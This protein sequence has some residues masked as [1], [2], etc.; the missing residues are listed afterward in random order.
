MHSELTTDLSKL[1]SNLTGMKTNTENVVLIST[2]SFNPVHRCHLSN[3]IRTKEYFENDCG[4]NVLAGY[5]SPTHDEYVRE[6][7]REECLPGQL[8]IQLCE[9]A[10]EEA[11]QQH[12]LAVDKAEVMG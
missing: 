4:F 2:G 11:N 5:L 3:L 8:R 1:R 6:K 7:L 12:W 9:K 10:I